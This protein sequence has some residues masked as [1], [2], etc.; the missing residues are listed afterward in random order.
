MRGFAPVNPKGDLFKRVPRPSKTHPFNPTTAMYG[1]ANAGDL[2]LRR[3][4]FEQN[5]RR[6]TALGTKQ[7]GASD[8]KSKSTR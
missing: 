6:K 7:G 1:A 8:I 4:V 3:F 2:C 5:E